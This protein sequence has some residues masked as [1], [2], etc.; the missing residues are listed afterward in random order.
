M[1]SRDA[2]AAHEP[3]IDAQRN[4]A[5]ILRTAQAVLA[6]D[7]KATMG[8]IAER[9]EVGRRTLNRRFPTRDALIAQLLR[10]FTKAVE[11]RI[12]EAEPERGDARE[13]LRRATLAFLDETQNWRASRYT[14]MS[15]LIP[16]NDPRG[17]RLRGRI[18]AVIE[19]GQREGAFRDDLPAPLLQDAWLGLQVIWITSDPGLTPDQV[20]DAILQLISAPV[21]TAKT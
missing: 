2:D 12:D 5:R 19:R 15:S 11:Q 16:R 21:P 13:A 7:P 3:R 17:S 1:G 10:E 18:I 14:P 9:A 6:E 8:E 20:A 4:I